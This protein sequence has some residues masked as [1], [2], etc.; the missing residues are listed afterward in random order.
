MMR[1]EKALVAP[2]R[3]IVFVLPTSKGFLTFVGAILAAIIGASATVW[4]GYWQRQPAATVPNEP[5][6]VQSVQPTPSPQPS[7]APADAGRRGS[8]RPASKL[9]GGQPLTV[10]PTSQ[11]AQRPPSLPS[12]YPR[13]PGC[14]AQQYRLHTCD[15]N[16]PLANKKPERGYEYDLRTTRI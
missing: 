12:D 11:P 9:I 2:T 1:T 8:N 13:A 7:P 6:A 5:R 4:T 16:D 14:T 15:P 10:K 3:P